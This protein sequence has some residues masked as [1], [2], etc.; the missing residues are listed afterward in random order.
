MC[1]QSKENGVV[2]LMQQSANWLNWL[3]TSKLISTTDI[4]VDDLTASSGRKASMRMSVSVAFLAWNWRS[5]APC[6]LIGQMSRDQVWR[7]RRLD[8]SLVDNA[9][10]YRLTW[11]TPYRE[12][13]GKKKKKTTQNKATGTGH[14]LH[15][16][17][18]AMKW[19][20][21]GRQR[22]TDRLPFV[23]RGR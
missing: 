6:I 14:T 10:L 19:G 21:Y 18:I 16:S 9:K 11:R 1:W 7:R 2:A 20:H 5:Y 12:R 15:I 13:E 3:H 17:A 8:A 4:K 23:W 22:V